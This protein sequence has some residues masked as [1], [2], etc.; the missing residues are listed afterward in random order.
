MLETKQCSACGTLFCEPEDLP[1]GCPHCRRMRELRRKAFLEK[2]LVYLGVSLFIVLPSAGYLYMK[3][4]PY[5]VTS[6][7]DLSD[8]AAWMVWFALLVAG[9]MSAAFVYV[10]IR[11][12][13]HW[14]KEKNA[15]I[16]AAKTTIWWVI[17]DAILLLIV[18]WFFGSAG[19][20]FISQ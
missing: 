6:L 3:S 19:M 9:S 7:F 11:G 13:W 1:S 5:H 4:P 16:K 8:P 12:A 10:M 20:R 15:D 14:L 2:C 18:A 17:V